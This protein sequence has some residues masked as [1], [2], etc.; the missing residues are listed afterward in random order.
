VLDVYEYRGRWKVTVQA[1]QGRP[2]P[3]TNAWYDTWYSD[4]RNMQLAFLQDVMVVY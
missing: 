3:E 4:M 2:F 1:L